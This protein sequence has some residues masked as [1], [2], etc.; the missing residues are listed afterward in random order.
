MINS[1][2][3]FFCFFITLSLQ[4]CGSSNS[5]VNEA[6]VILQADKKFCQY[7][8]KKGFF[9]AFL[10]YADDDIVKLGEERFPVIGKKELS[11]VFDGRSGTKELIWEP[12][13][14]KLAESGELGYT[15]GN[16]HFNDKDK[17]TTYYGNYFTVWKK[18][19]DGN[20]K[21]LLDEEILL[22]HR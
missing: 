17:D 21:V 14:G 22:H 18:S 9:K 4:S 8:V 16:W 6:E 1:Y 7:S 15:W 2:K 11:K 13:D 19:P 10:K 3:I 20:W 5:K 12:V